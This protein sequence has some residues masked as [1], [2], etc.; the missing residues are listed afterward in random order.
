M[1]YVLGFAFDTYGRLAL[2][3]KQRPDYQ[4]GKYN[5]IG[6]K[7]EP[8]DESLAHAMEREFR[9]ETGVTVPHDQWRRCAT[10]GRDG[11]WEVEVFTC[12]HKD[13][14]NVKTTT[15][16]EVRL[17]TCRWFHNNE[18]LAMENVPLLIQVALLKPGHS[19]QVPHVSLD[20]RADAA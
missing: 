7:V 4:R 20:Y 12:R 1:R 8:D 18:H 10:M 5:G 16:E 2:I 9:E 15:D 3:L 17:V 19:G 6:G 14:E 11:I 13:V